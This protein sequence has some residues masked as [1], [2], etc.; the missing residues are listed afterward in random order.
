[1]KPGVA[2]PS[3]QRMRAFP[4]LH[5]GGLIEAGAA[6]WPTIGTGVSPSTG[7]IEARPLVCVI[8]DTCFPLYTEGASL[9]LGHQG[10]RHLRKPP[11]PPLHRGGLI[12]AVSS[13]S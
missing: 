3:S 4:P 12:Q 7:L 1:M 8:S 11:V 9:K 6:N 13:L 5:G 2:R 10:L